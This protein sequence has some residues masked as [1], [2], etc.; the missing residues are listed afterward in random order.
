MKF[1]DYETLLKGSDPKVRRAIHTLHEEL[2]EIKR[3]Q[4]QLI[5]FYTAIHD[6][7]NNLVDYVSAHNS[8]K[9]P[10]K[11]ELSKA[12]QKESRAGQLGVSVAPDTED[13]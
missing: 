7:I 1:Q 12:I 4:N 10:K 6:V 8:V 3:Q 9:M 5:L 13:T 2:L 11:D